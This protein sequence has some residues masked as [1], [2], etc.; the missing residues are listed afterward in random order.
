MMRKTVIEV[1]NGLLILFQEY[2]FV[3]NGNEI[4]I[5]Y[6]LIL[7]LVT[8]EWVSKCVV[9]FYLVYIF[10]NYYSKSLLNF[11]QSRNQKQ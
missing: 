5:V 11:E 8:N 9:Y 6:G 1:G 10:R 3:G 2:S 7:N 4:T